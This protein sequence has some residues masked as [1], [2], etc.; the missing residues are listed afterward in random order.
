MYGATMADGNTIST[1]AL[2]VIAVVPVVATTVLGY[3]ASWLAER[4]QQKTAHGTWVR[5]RRYDAYS[6]LL[7]AM[8]A[9]GGY[10]DAKDSDGVREA[11]FR[12]TEARAKAIL[13]SDSKAALCIVNR[14]RELAR[15]FDPDAG[16]SATPKPGDIVMDLRN[17]LTGYLTQ[18]RE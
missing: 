8:T 17:E 2:V 1:T 18:V 16:L 15:L 3:V 14:T 5:E 11:A 12:F 9:F 7:A 13:L 10:V 4:R 6:E